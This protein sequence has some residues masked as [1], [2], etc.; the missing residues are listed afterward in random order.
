M[1]PP[2]A[3]SDQSLYRLLADDVPTGDLTTESLGLCGQPGR[4]EFHARGPMTVCGTEEAVRLFIL[5]G[6]VARLAMPS[7][8]TVDNGTV[9]LTAEG[10]VDALH[11]AWKTAQTLIEWASGIASG[12]AALVHAAASIPV[13]CTRKN[14]PGTKALSIK[15]IQSGGAIIHRLGLSE[16]LLIFAEHR[17]FLDE[18]PD[19]TIVR[20]HTRQ[21]EKK[22]VVEVS[23]EGEALTWAQAG[24]DVLQLEKFTP[25]ALRAC[26]ERLKA[27]GLHPVL[28][29]AGGVRVDNAADYVAA[30]AD[31]IA[32]SAP[33]SA[34]PQ[35]VQVRFFKAGRDGQVISHK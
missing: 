13:A 21:P 5:A 7:G 10:S 14:A 34:A 17:Q 25:V 1:L 12:A 11:R 19:A 4:L 33:Y 16:T 18:P 20:L 15:A 31:L 28:A 30:G 29:A 23:S 3:L 8:A 32:T 27:E 9:L 35:D 2:C 22:I 26:R 24:A 6:A